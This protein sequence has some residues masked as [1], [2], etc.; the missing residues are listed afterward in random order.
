MSVAQLEHSFSLI[1]S[2][3][4]DE[5]L[6]G[7]ILKEKDAFFKP[8]KEALEKANGLQKV[9]TP[10]YNPLKDKQPR[11][12]IHNEILKDENLNEI[13]WLLDRA[14]ERGIILE[15]SQLFFYGK[16]SRKELM[17]DSNIEVDFGQDCAN[18]MIRGFN[19]QLNF[20]V[21]RL[22]AS[23]NDGKKFDVKL[24]QQQLQALGF[25]WEN[26]KEIRALRPNIEV[27]DRNTVVIRGNFSEIP[28]PCVAVEML[29][30]LVQKIKMPF[31]GI[32][33]LQFKETLHSGERRFDLS[34]T[35]DWYDFKQYLQEVSGNKMEFIEFGK[36]DGNHRK[37]WQDDPP[38]DPSKYISVL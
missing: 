14:H 23:Q 9:A 36:E 37:N 3:K 16:A 8:A 32:K 5:E 19:I 18:A 27:I 28:N 12:L 13:C 24:I 38:C 11:F 15:F 34:L 7:A 17:H 20:L 31:Y 35:K 25:K 29:A 26:K 30:P 21:R 1:K 10:L 22:Q 4:T 33:N 6:Q 2:Y